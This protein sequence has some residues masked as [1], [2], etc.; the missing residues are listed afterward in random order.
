MEHLVASSQ[1]KLTDAVGENNAA[2]HMFH[3]INNTG[4]DPLFST[5][6]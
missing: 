2:R 5:T 1:A 4:K 6:T 3:Y